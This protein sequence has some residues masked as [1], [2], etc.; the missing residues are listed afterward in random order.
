MVGSP[1]A[2][3]VVFVVGGALALI[4]CVFI[5]RIGRHVL[6]SFSHSDGRVKTSFGK[7]SRQVEKTL[8]SFLPFLDR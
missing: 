5:V 4:T 2:Q 8:R 6:V 3:Q 1:H 7:T